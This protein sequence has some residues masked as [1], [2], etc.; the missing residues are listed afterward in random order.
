MITQFGSLFAGHV[1]LEQLD[2]DFRLLPDRV[3]EAPV[4]RGRRIDSDRT[5]STP[6]L[7]AARIGGLQR[8]NRRHS[9]PNHNA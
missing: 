8:Y 9:Q 2:D 1:D 6:L 7:C 4:Y 3:V 5:H